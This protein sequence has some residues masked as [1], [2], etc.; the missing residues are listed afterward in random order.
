MHSVYIFC[1]YL[2]NSIQ[3]QWPL[4]EAG[5]ITK[6]K[7]PPHYYS[8]Y[9]YYYFVIVLVNNYIVPLEFL[10]WESRVAFP[11]KS[12]LRQGRATQPTVHAGC[13]SVSI[14]HR[15]LTWTTGSVTCAQMLMPVIAHKGV[16]TP[17]ESLH[18]KL[19]LGEKA[20]AAPG[21]RTCLSG[22]TLRRSSNWA[23]SPQKIC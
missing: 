13:F 4:A 14:I 18:W 22:V 2:V 23:T 8:Y 10:P 11:G 17:L 3:P 7:F 12:L 19:T 20:L 16:R 21:N 6:K 15:T 9:Y 1:T 5:S